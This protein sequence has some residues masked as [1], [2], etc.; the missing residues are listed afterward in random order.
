MTLTQKPD[1][2]EDLIGPLDEVFGFHAFRPNQEE[3]IRAI[4]TRRDAFA[5]MPTGGGKSLCYQLPAHLLGGTC[6]VISPLISLMKDQV[7][8]VRDNGIRAEYF[9]SSLNGLQRSEVLRR[10][11][12]G[13]LDL[14]YVAPERFAMDSFLATLK[15]VPVCFFAID[16]AHCISEW[17]H[18][19][20]PDY[21]SLSLIVKHFPDVPVAAFTA[22]ATKRVQRDIIDRLAL[23]NP[24][25]VR[26]SFDRPN[27]FYEVADKD[28]V[29]RQILLFLHNRRDESG[30]I[31]RTTRADVEGTAAYLASHDVKV[32]PYHA[33]LDSETRKKNQDAFNRDEINVIVAT[34][35]FGMGIDKSNVRFVVHGDLPKNIEGY[36]QETGRAGRDGEP[37]HCL[38]FFGRGDTST[39]RYFINQMEDEAQRSIA[40]G[41][42]GEMVR[43]A[44]ANA[45]RRRQLLDYFGETLEVDNCGTCDVCTSSTEQADATTESQIIMSAILRTGQRFGAAH[46]VDVVTGANTKKIRDLRHNEIKTYGAGEDKDK[47]FWRRIIDDL[48]AQ[49]CLIQTEGQ[50]PVLQVT[51]RGRE[52]LFGREEFYIIRRPETQGHGRSAVTDDYNREL[53]EQLRSVR[54]R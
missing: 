14:L 23:R 48:L 39:I 51:L 44:T 27:L 36:Y 24:H 42:L 54:T 47:R 3:I 49:K 52:V 21:L 41:K 37:A 4:L 33:G 34:I 9:N 50:Y 15:A 53:F 1:K 43:Y 25:T 46:V 20:R 11:S 8:A 7:D 30:I 40:S 32:R 31:Y 19:F 29:D 26:A 6:I 10:L 28:D 2:I 18:D 22:T 17:G 16:E 12:G 38:L 5:V 35:A 45:C 13:E